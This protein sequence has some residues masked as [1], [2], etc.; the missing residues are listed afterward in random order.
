MSELISTEAK[1]RIRQPIDIDF[2][3]E[4][5]QTDNG[6]YTFT[7]P[8]LWT[9][10][11]NLFYLLKNSV[12]VDLQPKYIRKPYLL[13]YDQYATVIL[14]FLLMYVNGIFCSEDFDMTTVVL[15]TISSII[16]ICQDKFSKIENTDTLGIVN[17]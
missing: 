13:S 11:K 12:E 9:I 5:Y 1:Q 8:S 16:E 17:W 14:E 6:L 10:E 2:M 7:S 15:P 3:G 4:R